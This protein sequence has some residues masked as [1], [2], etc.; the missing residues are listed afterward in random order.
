M[1]LKT[2][3]LTAFAA[4]AFAADISVV[5]MI[6]AK[7]NSEI[8][9]KSEID[10]LRKQIETDLKAKHV[11]APEIQKQIKDREKDFL[12]EKIDQSL[13]VQKG[14]DLAIK[15]EP[16]VIK[17]IANIQRESGIADPDKFRAWLREQTGMPYEDFRAEV[18]NG[19]LTQRVIRQEVGSR[20]N[21]TKAEV[22]KFYEENKASFVREERVFLRELL[23]STA[24]KD[25]PGIAAAEKRAK[26]LAARAKKGE[27]F[28]ELAKDHSDSES[29]ENFGELPPFKKGE[30][31]KDLED[32][33]WDKERS[34]VSDAIKRPNGFLILKVEEHQK[35][36]QAA[37]EEVE[38]EIHE[39]IYQPRMPVLLREYLT[40]LR[41][42]AF[43]EIRDGYEDS[44][45]APGKVTKWTD[46]AQ[47]KPETVDKAEVAGRTKKKK[48]LWAVPIPGTKASAN[49]KSR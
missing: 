25:A 18:T 47:L 14:K 31:A 41:E 40:K 16:E 45:A 1:L 13:L 22:Q 11:E 35:A 44:G 42:D 36:G 20:I 10:R 26:D 21:I 46:P 17:Y 38:N 28:P 29:K 30:L 7:I 4:Q 48:L 43:L 2:C 24:G 9:T 6:V 19:M 33:V 12:R 15:V 3:L 32:A 49:S 34:F 27:K 37:L 23:I 5:D 39:K 8:I